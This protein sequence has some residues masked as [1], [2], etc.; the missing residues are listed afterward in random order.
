MRAAM[1]PSLPF[2]LFSVIGATPLAAAPVALFDGK[3]LAGWEIPAG[4]EKWW[5][6]Q[7]GSITGGILDENVPTNLFLST[8][9]DYRNF[10]LNLKIRIVKG[11]G[12]MNSGIQ[13]RSV[14]EPGRTSMQGY[15]VDAGI[16]YWGDLYDE[17]RREAKIAG[18]ID[19]AAIDRAVKPWDWND[20]R[21]LCEGRRIRSWING[22]P[23]LDYTESDSAIPL[24]GRIAV[25][26]HAGGK[27]L[28]E[29]KDV[30]LDELPDTPGA[31]S[32]KPGPPEI[33]A[34]E[35]AGAPVLDPAQELAAFKLPPGFVA[36]LVA[37]EIQGAGKP[38]TM[39]WD[40]RGRMWTMT[41]L[42]YPLDSNENP[43][44]TAALYARGGKDK[45]LIFDD[46]SATLPLTPHPFIEG[47]AIPLGLLPD[48][49]GKGALV[50]YGSQI[51]HYIDSDGDGKADRFDVVLDG[52]GTQDSHLMPHQ[53]E[54]APGGWIYVA[55]GLFNASSV[56]RPGMQPFPDGSTEKPFEACKLGRFRPDGS[57]FEA[58]T[59]GPNN[60]WGLLQSRL[61]ET[62]IQEANDMGIP[63]TEFIPGAHYVT[64]SR[65]KLRSYAP[66]M[67]YS[68]TVGMG[69]TGLSGLALAD[70]RDSRFAKFYGG[71]QV[72]YVANPITNRIQ[73]ISTDRT[74]NRHPE[75]FKREDFLV[76]TDP[77]F[78]PVSIHFGPDGFLY[79]ADWYNKIIS[80]NEVPRNHPDR[81]KVHGRIWRIRPA[82]QAPQKPQD[83]TILDA[84]SLIQ[85]I[86][87]PNSRIAATAVAMLA[88]SKSPEISDGLRKVI[89]DSKLPAER[90]V[91][92]LWA[93][94]GKGVVDAE[95]LGKLAADPL[96]ELRYEAVRAATEA[97]LDPAAFA[98]IFSGFAQDPNYR[99]R[100]GL[101]NAVRLHPAADTGMLALAAHLGRAP[102][103][104]GNRW[105]VYDRE[106]ERYL[107][108]WALEMHQAA[109]EAMLKSDA[110]TDPEERLLAIQALPPE[111]AAALLVAELPSL[112]RPLTREEL[113]ILGSQLGQPVVLAGFEAVLGDVTKRKAVLGNLSRLDP[114]QLANPALARIV[115]KACSALVAAEPG[116]DNR[117]L[118][119]EL[120]RRFR[121]IELEPVIADW[122]EHADSPVNAARALAAL[123]EMKS[124]RIELFQ[125]L[126]DSPDEAVRREALGALAAVNDPKVVP[127]IA[128]RWDKLPGA[129]RTL[130]VNGLTSDR[131]KA[132]AF[133]SSAG[134]GA[135][136]NLEGGVLERLLLILGEKDPAMQ[137]LL[138]KNEGL[139]ARVIRLP[140]DPKGIVPLAIDLAGAFTVETWI[141][142]DPGIDNSDNLLGHHGG[143]DFNFYGEHFRVYD[144]GGDLIVANRAMAP[145]VWTHVALT[146]DERGSMKI[147]LDGELDQDRCKPSTATFGAMNIGETNPGLGCGAR[148]DEFRIWNVARTPDEIRADFHTRYAGALPPH[149][150]KRISGESPGT[151]NVPAVVEWVQDFPQLVTPDQAAANLKKFAHFRDVASRG[152]DP[153][154]GRALFQATCMICH[155]VR[156]EGAQIGPDLSGVGAMGLEGILRNVLDP[157]A[158]LESGYYRHDVTTDDGATI[159]G[160][161]VSETR[162]ALTIRP[163]GSEPKIIPAATI[164][165]HHVSK[166][167]LMPEGLLDGMDEEKVADLFSYLTTLK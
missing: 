77:C 130:V 78:R 9:K 151:L 51:R 96:P 129:M 124:G 4:E 17:H 39:A 45:V 121:L 56:H 135:F 13:V 7:D 30:T 104:G 132:A 11:E 29:M 107:A 60:I 159:S 48:L 136:Q 82:D 53:F 70:D 120:A 114:A 144:G 131:A 6:V 92:A 123:H 164:V 35:A 25:Q 10:E 143:A 111:R 89:L 119:L 154:A 140:G 115:A 105:E 31:P 69:G 36:E 37:S 167:S 155:Q 152:G 117:P 62:W 2:L 116:N 118:V 28:V 76:S 50:H 85:R 68:L 14:R 139:V 59:A 15:Q 26:L 27:C 79:V 81:D 166:R 99:V 87:D 138:K 19:Q 21:I 16:G 88:A 113:A 109:T 106:F 57:D 55:Q 97:K 101:A 73:A 125:K 142:L 149:L 65:D 141:R 110:L 103:T 157:N 32:W 161:L 98:K 38:I 93:L 127:L 41:A 24:D 80:H 5:R 133:A 67:P 52:F 84:S 18:A 102:L 1:K 22:V 146:R 91:G 75:Y 156:G 100:A 145:D 94:E 47:L 137:G 43:A 33:P 61:G 54:R 44:A 122:A 128:S 90:R 58:L 46:P 134:E 95:V 153:A 23:A 165:R 64:G 86:D 20:Y 72:I 42:E 83:L 147:F 112:A 160:F 148:Y 74:P 158:Q 49:D 8:T 66:Q 34:A 3:S 163:I 40:A 108:R 162:E 71:D 150:V 12:F 126:L 63:V